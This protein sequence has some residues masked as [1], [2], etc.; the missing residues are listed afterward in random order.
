M[1]AKENLRL[2]AGMILASV[3]DLQTLL[4]L[5]EG[6]GQRRLAAE[7]RRQM[8]KPQVRIDGRPQPDAALWLCGRVR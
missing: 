6:A 8:P 7:M 1:T 4:G 5:L 2:A 3:P